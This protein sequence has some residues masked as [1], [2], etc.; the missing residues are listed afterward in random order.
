LMDLLKRKYLHSL[1]EDCDEIYGRRGLAGFVEWAEKYPK[2]LK[3]SGYIK[4]VAEYLVEINLQG[5]NSRTFGVPIEQVL[6][7]VPFEINNFL[8]EA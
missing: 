1:L 6:K 2:N 3:E 7:N 4:R 8:Q 5:A